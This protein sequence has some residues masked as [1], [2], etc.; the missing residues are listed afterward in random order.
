MSVPATT[1]AADTPALVPA[2]QVAEIV[3]QVLAPVLG[4][5]GLMQQQ[6]LEEFNQSR[7]QMYESFANL[8]REHASFLEDELERLRL[9]S[10]E[11]QAVHADLDA[12]RGPWASALAASPEPSSVPALRPAFRPAP[13]VRAEPDTA[14]VVERPLR[15]APFLMETAGP[16]HA[17]A[18][19][20]DLSPDA[21][22]HAQLCDRI[23]RLKEE[24]QSRWRK[25]LGM[26]PTAMGG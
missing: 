19:G 14:S 4:Q 26:F 2:S 23:A 16:P 22:V 12:S 10:Q 3:E 9:I 13:S 8:H 6:M 11:M 15:S 7:V 5:V 17:P 18:V 20:P 1:A 24:H 25:L 21:T